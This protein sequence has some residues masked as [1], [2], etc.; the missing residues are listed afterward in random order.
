M[1]DRPGQSDR[2]LVPSKPPNRAG[3][4]AAEGAEGKGAKGNPHPA[5]P[6][7]WTPCRARQAQEGILQRRDPP[8][9]VPLSLDRLHRFRS[10]NGSSVGNTF[11]T[12]KR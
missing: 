4:L 1:L 12:I 2:P 6:A 11:S 3:P 5:R 7:Y 9:P 8:C 10:S